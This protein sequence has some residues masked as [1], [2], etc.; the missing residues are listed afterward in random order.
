MLK[1]FARLALSIAVSL[2]ILALILQLVTTGL[3]EDQ[4]PSVWAA[5]AMTTKG[6]LFAYLGLYFVQLY[7]R[8]SRY[9]L[10]LDIA[11]EQNLPTLKQ[12]ALVTGIRN[13]FVDMLPGRVGELGYVAL[14]NRGYGVKLEH[15]MSSLG[16][17]I[18]FDFVALF[19]IALAIVTKQLL[20]ASVEI[21]AL[22]ALLMIFVVTVIGL[23]AVFYVFPWG[24]NTFRAPLQF[25]QAPKWWNRLLDW[26]VEFATSI[27]QVRDSGRL[28]H[29]SALSII[30]RVLKYTGMYLLFMA[31]A[32]PSFQSLANLPFEQIIGALVGGEVGASLPV[33]TFM[34]FGAYEAGSTLVFQLLGV[35]NQAE[36]FVTMLSV[37]IWSQ[38]MD[39]TI[40]GCL[41]AAFILLHRRAQAARALVTTSTGGVQAQPAPLFKR[42]QVW[43]AYAFSAIALAAAVLFLA[44]QLWTAS[45]LGAATAPPAGTVNSAALDA[46]GTALAAV[47]DINGFVVFSSNRDGN[48]DIFKLE[49]TTGDLTKLTSHPHTET[50]P[51]LSPDGQRLV[52][53]RAHQV[54]VSQ[55]NTQAWDVIV[56]DI[57]TGREWQVG[58]QGTSPHWVDN[59]H[60]TFVRNTKAVVKVNV[61]TLDRQVVFAANSNIYNARY[62]PN[63]QQTTFTARQSDIGL[64]TGSWG[65]AITAPSEGVQGVLNGCELAWNSSYTGLF[66]V[67]PST[68]GSAVEIVTINPND[69]SATPLID[70]QGEF[71]HE[72]WPKDSNDGQYMVFG[73]SRGP[74]DHEH[75]TK[76]YEIFLWR[77]GSDPSNATRLTF[78]T[79]NDNWPDMHVR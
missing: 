61:D 28:L 62:N 9:R 63:T 3:S 38:L 7:F 43:G 79:G 8:A 53:A 41:L 64:N 46:R 74:Q 67:T 11:G 76:D 78:H 66:Q 22:N 25:A 15:C 33:P 60:I 50:Y 45:K 5:L 57:A 16:L 26:S 59:Q 29:V 34:S 2:A 30:V 12:M 37:H 31:V 51:R 49:L 44:V 27:T 4:R 35:A 70:L 17:A 56:L 1:N 47:N 58:K 21:W 71:N 73:A 77:K 24:V 65:T 52:F 69:F 75:D 42:W 6:W 20:G 39:Y 36:A 23:L 18:V 40:G 48:H 32:V 14:L 10:L 19:V 72:Y 54:W 13:M 55:R 68:G